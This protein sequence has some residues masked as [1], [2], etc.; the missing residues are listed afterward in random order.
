M[1]ISHRDSPIAMKRFS[2][3]I[4]RRADELGRDPNSFKIF[5]TVRPVVGGSHE[6]ALA[7]QRKERASHSSSLEF[8][9]A[10]VSMRLGYD[11]S[12]F[13]LDEPL[14]ADL[15]SR[16]KGVEGVFQQYTE[17]GTRTLREIA[18]SQASNETF[19][20]V[21]SPREVADRFEELADEAQADGFAIQGTLTPADVL[22]FVEQ[23]AP[24]LRERG[25]TRRRFRYETF[26]ENLHDPEFIETPPVLTA[27][28]GVS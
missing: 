12:E 24:L 18:L 9:L 27:A 2:E 3:D 11:V 4:R 22:P 6:E 1:I 19:P 8:G 13:D 16:L 14:P 20:I 7:L 15:P 17:N 25:L 26:R 23:V 10:N 28:K 21:G 5:F